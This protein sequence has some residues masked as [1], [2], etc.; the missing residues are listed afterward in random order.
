M[1]SN[2][3][4]FVSEMVW[5]QTLSE[6]FKWY[7]FMNKH[8]STVKA[9]IYANNMLLNLN[10]LMSP[11]EID[12]PFEQYFSSYSSLSEGNR[13]S[14][15]VTF[16]LGII[17]LIFFIAVTLY[18]CVT[19]LPIVIK[20][21]DSQTEKLKKALAPHEFTNKVAFNW[22]IVT[23]VKYIKTVLLLLCFF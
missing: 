20:G 2:V 14:L 1:F 22:W 18:L 9:V 7:R 5:V 19:T 16:L 11:P 3:D 12:R 6:K 17:N 15:R 4:M 8:F 10:V 13:A 23:L 21:I